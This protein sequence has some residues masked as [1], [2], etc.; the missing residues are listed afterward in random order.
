MEIEKAIAPPG[1]AMVWVLLVL[2][3]KTKRVMVGCLDENFN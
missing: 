2:K 3:M 1:H